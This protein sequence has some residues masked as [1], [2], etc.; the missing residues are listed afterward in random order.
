MSEGS[1]GRHE[2]MENDI[3]IQI[4]VI[5]LKKD[6]MLKVETCPE[7]SKQNIVKIEYQLHNSVKSMTLKVERLKGT[8]YRVTHNA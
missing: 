4:T 5:I 3:F 7:T 1:V 8:E 2:Q 6:E